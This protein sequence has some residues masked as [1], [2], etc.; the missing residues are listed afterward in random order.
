[1]ARKQYFVSPNSGGLLMTAA[2]KVTTGG[3]TVKT[4]ATQDECSTWAA[5][6]ARA[7]W[8]QKGIPTQVL[9]QRPGGQFREE[10][11]YGNDP[12]PPRG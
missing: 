6:T 5:R 4:G 7:E 8:E 3:M 10:W 12:N 1:M 11:T 2:W 9:I